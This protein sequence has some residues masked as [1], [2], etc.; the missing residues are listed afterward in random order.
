M[1]FLRR[2]R[3]ETLILQA[4]RAGDAGVQVIAGLAGVLAALALVQHLVP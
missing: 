3:S 1:A 2:H 4:H